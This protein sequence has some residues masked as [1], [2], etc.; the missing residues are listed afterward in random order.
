MCEACD[1]HGTGQQCIQRFGGKNL[2]EDA[3][4]DGLGVDG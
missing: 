2:K 1:K 3:H 4:F